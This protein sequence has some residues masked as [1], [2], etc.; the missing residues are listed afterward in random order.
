MDRGG[1]TKETIEWM[2]KHVFAK[3]ETWKHHASCKASL[4]AMGWKLTRKKTNY[5]MISKKNKT[6]YDKIERYD[7]QKEKKKQ[8][9]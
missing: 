5:L 3:S 8:F 7:L 6:S 2:K 4:K 1:I 9:Y